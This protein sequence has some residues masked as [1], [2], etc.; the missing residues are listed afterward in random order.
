MKQKIM[1][2]LLAVLYF[3]GI[4]CSVAVIV[5]RNHSQKPDNISSKSLSIMKKDAIAI[6]NISGPIRI[7]ARPQR[8][9]PFDSE[10]T[11]EKLRAFSNDNDVKAIILRIN[12]PGGS[13]AAVQEIYSEINRARQK[14]KIIVASMGDVAASG[15]YYVASACDKI[16]AD[17]GTL[18]G[19]IGVILEIAN[20]Q[21]LFKKIGVKMQTIKSG[22]FK[23]TG[24]MYRELTEEEKTM[25]QELINE[26]YGQF[27]TAV[28]EGRKIPRET[29]LTFA[30]G[31]V[32]TG[33]Q[34]IKLNMI[35]FLG[36]DYDA[37]DIAKKAANIKGEPK[38]ITEYSSVE[39]FL[40]MFGDQKNEMPFGELLGKKGVRFEYIL[41]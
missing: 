6:I 23:D 12:S 7:S 25:F 14:G 31:R 13:V 5:T 32:F 22:K 16:V 8:L 24:S 28:S 40:S 39:K 27:V 21:E 9:F 3:L 18:T 26:A 20:V 29:V 33:T 38:I 34:A 37:I 17:P 36:N 1:I 19:S 11:T 4:I 41:E 35:D 30:D 2:Y 15:G 10:S